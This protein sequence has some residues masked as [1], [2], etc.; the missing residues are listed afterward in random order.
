MKKRLLLIGNTNGLPG[1]TR[2]IHNYKSFFLSDYGGAWDDSEIIT[3]MNPPKDELESKLSKLKSMSL[4]FLIVVFSGH[5]GHK[6][7]T[8]L[9]INEFDEQISE[10]ELDNLADRQINIYDC[11]R[12]T[13]A[14][15]I[16]E[17]F[18]RSMIKSAQVGLKIR[19]LYEERIMQAIPQIVNLY[20]CS[21][22]E[23][24]NDTVN[25]GIYTNCLLKAARL[26]SK[27]FSLVSEAHSSALECTRNKQKNQNPDATLP[28]CLS[29]QSLVLSINPN[30]G[31]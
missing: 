5:G 31:R 4:D 21:I 3:K 29:S 15:V 30:L 18:D 28:K 17:G 12:A 1:V 24:S 19:K 7:K 23:I 6:R 10:E 9:E 8:V 26:V 2:D 11:C 20:S 16:S 22:G 25:G 13:T 14:Q 27:D